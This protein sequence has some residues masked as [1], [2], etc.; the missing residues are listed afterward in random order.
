MFTMA[1]S[2]RGEADGGSCPGHSKR[3]GVKLPY[4]DI[5]ILI[6]YN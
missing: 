1:A 3:G 6:F 5:N 4:F 2:P